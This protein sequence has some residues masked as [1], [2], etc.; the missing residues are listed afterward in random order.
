MRTTEL[1]E[2]RQLVTMTSDSMLGI[3]HVDHC[4]SPPSLPLDRERSWNVQS[5]GDAEVRLKQKIIMV[6]TEG[7]RLLKTK[8][9]CSGILKTFG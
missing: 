9:W 8:R 5:F 4:Y 6:G 2:T 7:N 1:S 3:F